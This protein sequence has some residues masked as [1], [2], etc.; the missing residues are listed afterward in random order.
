MG[1]ADLIK[2]HPV[3]LPKHGLIVKRLIQHLHQQTGHGGRTTTMNALRQNGYWIISAST[4]VKSTIHL[5]ISCQK[6]RGKLGKQKMANLPEYRIND[7]N[8]PP[9]SYCGVDMFGTFRIKQKRT[10][11]KRFVT[12]FTCLTSR[13]IHLEVTNEMSIDSFILCLCK[14]SCSPWC[15]AAHQIR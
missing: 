10:Q 6:Y 11:C 14:I 15:N 12:L 5:C 13:A 1:K 4:L 2:K 9:F 7:A 3:V 8:L